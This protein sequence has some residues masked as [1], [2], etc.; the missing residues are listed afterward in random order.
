MLFISVLYREKAPVQEA[1]SFLKERFGETLLSTDPMPFT[2][3]SYYRG[4]MGSPLFRVVLAFEKLVPRDSMPETKLFTNALE[5]TL[6][7]DGKRVINLDPGILSLENICLATTKPYSHRIYL[8]QGIWAEIT[9]MFKG[10]SYQKLNWTYPD[11]ASAGMIGIFNDMREKYRRRL[12][13][14]G[15]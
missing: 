1:V 3:T 14:R 4:E 8:S 10:N 6:A 12:R 7:R 5:Q 11:Y 15:A 2:Y 13:C 9:L